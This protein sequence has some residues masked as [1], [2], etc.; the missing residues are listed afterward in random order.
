ML[1][2][3]FDDTNDA[4]VHATPNTAATQP[5]PAPV[6]RRRRRRQTRV[7]AL[8]ALALVGGTVGGGVAG[9]VIGARAV[10]PA[11][12]QVAPA[13]IVSPQQVNTLGVAGATAAS[14][15]FDQVNAGVVE[16][17][18][19][20]QVSSNGFSSGSGSGF[21]VDAD[22]LI[23]T[24]YHV[25]QN[26]RQISVTFSTGE[27]REATILG[28]DEGNDLALLRVDLPANI[29]VLAMADSDQVTVGETAIA[30]GS[31]FGLSETV[32]QGIISAVNRDWWPGNGRVQR[33]L[34]QTDAPINP[35]NSGGPLLNANG[36]VIG[37]NSM[38]ESPV[39]GSVGVGF[40]IPINTA[41]ALIPQ[42]EAGAQLKPV[43]LG[44]S[45]QDI[46]Q[47]IAE[48]QGLSVTEGVLVTSV[49]PG[50]PAD[51]ANLQGGS[52]ENER[53]PRGGDVIT[54]IDGTAITSMT[55]LAASLSG[56]EPGDVV[57]VTVL[58]DGTQ[59][60]IAVT[61]QAWP[62]NSGQ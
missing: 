25:V 3:R 14:V 5:Q 15:V 39:R 59:Q 2:Y 46:D 51:T 61:L 26:A 33:N 62:D 28:T 53:I 7:S 49:V 50:G 4:E 23:L 24:N 18:V 57:T 35:G 13:Q 8:L 54:A 6:S 27:Q 31:P 19:A 22:G 32:T 36:E 17:T 56:R 37:I 29:S 47:A 42:L 20:G 38:I 21:V 52:G 16:I 30:I 58:R 48:D 45:G 44:I 1:P 10:A 9:T 41:K 11:T 60:E 43:W 12:A 55:D 40:A 34:L